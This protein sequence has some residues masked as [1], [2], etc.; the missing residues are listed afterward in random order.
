MT[1]DS[2]V[3]REIKEIPATNNVA[4]RNDKGG[5]NARELTYLEAIRDAL[6]YEMRRDAR[7]L[8]MGEDVGVFGGAFKVTL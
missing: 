7:V 3:Q 5:D 1:W 6:Q 2:I 8:V 4:V